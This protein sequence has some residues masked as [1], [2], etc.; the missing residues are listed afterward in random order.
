LL[1][2]LALF[3]A[4]SGG[5]AAAHHRPA[6]SPPVTVRSEVTGTLLIAAADDPPTTDDAEPLAE[7]P[8]LAPALDWYDWDRLAECESGGRWDAQGARYGGGLQILTSTWR[9]YGG[10][11]FADVPGAATREQQIVVG[12]AIQADGGWHQWPLCARRL[13]LA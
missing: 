1:F 4:L 9:A 7:D 5:N 13:G 3:L 6:Y 8:R 12:R 11:E 10:T 2:S